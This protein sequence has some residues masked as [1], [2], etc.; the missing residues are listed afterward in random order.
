MLT[1]NAERGA[2]AACSPAPALGLPLGNGRA[3]E[4]TVAEEITLEAERRPDT[5]A[6]AN[7]AQCGSLVRI[8]VRACFGLFT[9]PY[10][11][12]RLKFRFLF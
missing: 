1:R 11:N 3:L 12:L 2:S 8:H 10:I 4:A 6:K 7:R 5:Y 9:F